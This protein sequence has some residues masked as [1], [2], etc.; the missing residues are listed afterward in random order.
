MTGAARDEDGDTPAPSWRQRP[1]PVGFEIAYRLDG[2]TLEVDRTR[3]VDSI[4][5]SAVEQVRFLYAPGNISSKGYKTALR[6]SD[7][8]TVTFGNLSWR[9]LTDLDRDDRR[10][11]RFV[12]ALSAAIARAN[13]RAR[14]VAG[15]PRPIWLAVA[16]VGALSLAMLA[17]VTLR[18]LQQGAT[19]T[20]LIG[21]LLIAASFWQVWP[22][23]HLNRPRELA[24][25]AVPD[26]LVP[27]RAG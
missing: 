27:G 10:Y 24:T 15:R 6:L 20:A 9:S 23:V 8:R 16:V 2:D 4:R 21:I 19:T 12:S 5:L 3:R 22:L 14:F 18:A 25:G 13:P 11:H 7:G 26:E 17:A 1:R